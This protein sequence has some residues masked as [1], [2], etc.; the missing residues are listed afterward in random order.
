MTETASK[1]SLKKWIRTASNFIA[2]IPSL[3]NSSSLV[4]FFWSWILKDSIRVQEKK[5]KVVVLRSRPPQNVK[6]GTFTLQSCSGG[7]EMFKKAWCTSKV[8]VLLIYWF[9][10]PFL[11]PSS[12]SLLKPPRYLG[13]GIWTVWILAKTKNTVNS[14][15]FSF[16]WSH[17][18]QNL[19]Q[20]SLIKAALRQFSPWSHIN[21]FMKPLPLIL[22]SFGKLMCF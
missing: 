13:I 15:L 4:K 8:F 16:S 22:D 2:L 18:Q 14:S 3:V 9:F 20:K 12:L 5:T 19:C 17:H 1:T 21:P 11:L 10:L 6:L 7:E